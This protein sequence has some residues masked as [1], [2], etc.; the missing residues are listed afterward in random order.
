MHFT[1]RDLEGGDRL[2]RAP[3]GLVHGRIDRRTFIKMALAT[4]ATMA[5]AQSF[6][7]ELGDA[8]VTQRYNSAPWRRHTTTS[9]W[10]RDRRR[11]RRRPPRSRDRRDRPRPGG[12]RHRPARRRAQPAPLAHEHRSAR[13]WNYAAEPSPAVNGRS[14]ILPMGKVV[15]GGSSVNVMIWAR[16]HRNDFEF[17]ASETGDDA[18]NYANVLGSTSAS[19]T[20][21]HRRRGAARQG[22]P[23]LRHARPESESRRARIP[24][25]LRKRR[26]P[27]VRRHER[28]G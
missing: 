7:Q 14:L 4:G 28:L 25:R 15:G 9:W 20:G 10:V 5:A 13:D 12:R 24:G 2:L 19:R 6:A 1:S 17:W 21:R 27:D 22:R 18:W 16:G 11:R 26:D 3:G 23:A 8:A